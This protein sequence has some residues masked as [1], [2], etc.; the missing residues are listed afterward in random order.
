LPKPASVKPR[1][2]LEERKDT[3]PRAL[4]KLFQTTLSRCFDLTLRNKLGPSVERQVYNLLATRGMQRSEISAEFD[5]VVRVLN[6]AFGAA[7]RPIVRE[8]VVQLY[9]EYSVRREFT[10]FD[11]LT[12]QII[13]L[14]DKVVSDGLKPKH[15][16]GRRPDAKPVGRE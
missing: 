15:R 11:S 14:R 5:N 12:D 16:P 7:A 13:L 2:G 9:S 4:L 6:E 3:P 1:R 8:T 10:I